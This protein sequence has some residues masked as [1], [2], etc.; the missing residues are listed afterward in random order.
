[1]SEDNKR[2]AREF[3]ER[4]AVRG[5]MS[6]T[7]RGEFLG[8]PASGKQFRV[9]VIDII[10]IVDGKA[11]DHWGASDTATMLQQLGAT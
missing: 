1:M 5:T 8:I 6:G 2:L 3:Y 10:R 4:V 9:T 11:T 7:Q